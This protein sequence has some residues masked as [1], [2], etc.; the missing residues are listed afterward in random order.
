MDDDLRALL[1]RI[2][3]DYAKYSGRSREEREGSYDL[4][5]SICK[6]LF[7]HWPE[8]SLALSPAAQVPPAHKCGYPIYGGK[9]PCGNLVRGDRRCYRHKGMP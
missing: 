3:R 6:R 8:I 4:Y 7:K 2:D 9:W 1:E 5:E